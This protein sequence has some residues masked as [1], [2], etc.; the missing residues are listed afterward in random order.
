M[1]KLLAILATTLLLCSLFA[2]PV[3]AETTQE[4]LVDF[5]VD[6]ESG[7]SPRILHIGDPQI[8]D[9]TQYP[10]D[11]D[12]DNDPKKRLKDMEERCFR[13]IRQVVHNTQPDL[14]L[15]AGDLVYGSYDHSGEAF[16]ELV[17]FL[18]SFG[19]PWAPVYGNHDAETNMGVL[20]QNEQLINAEHCLFKKG[21]VTGNGNYTVGIRQNGKLTRVFFMMDSN[22]CDRPGK[23]SIMHVMPGGK[24]FM[25]DQVEWFTRQGAAIKEA[26]PDAN[27]S[28]VFHIPFVAFNDAMATAGRGDKG[29]IAKGNESFGYGIGNGSDWDRNHAIYEAMKELGTDSIL[30]GH[31]H[32]TSASVVYEG[33]RFQF[34]QKCSSYDSINYRLED[35]TIKGSYD[36]TTG[37]PIVGGTLM[38]MEEQTGDF[39]EFEIVLYKEEP[40][41]E[42]NNFMR[43][44]PAVCAVVPALLAAFVVLRNKKG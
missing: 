26:Y 25:E 37:E 1:K 36:P 31:L 6:V 22:G 23:E 29:L 12:A 20:W 5:I 41:E 24:G 33:I 2:I 42:K 40:K 11:P 17:K 27:V 39:T 4:P 32:H 30:V 8:V 3:G 18:D 44:I 34:A 14:I 21:D 13:Y 7:R 38:L 10:N 35:G 16:K 9:P 43:W 15:I 19:I 28:F